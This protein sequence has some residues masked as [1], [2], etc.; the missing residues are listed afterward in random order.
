MEIDLR[1][2]VAFITGGT[3]G[4][5]GA[6]TEVLAECGADVAFIARN[7]DDLK[8]MEVRI[9]SRSGGRAFAIQGDVSDASCLRNAVE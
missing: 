9:N 8:D 5:G 4:I 2:K 7:F 1:G 3:K 6:I